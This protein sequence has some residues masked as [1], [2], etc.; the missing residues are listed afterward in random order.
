[1]AREHSYEGW[2]LWKSDGQEFFR[3]PAAWGVR[4]LRDLEGHQRDLTAG[5]EI[6][7]GPLPIL[8]EGPAV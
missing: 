4:R 1:M 7:I 3:I 5:Q 2:I 8:L 6:E